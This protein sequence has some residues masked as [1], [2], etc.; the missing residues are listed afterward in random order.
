MARKGDIRIAINEKSLTNQVVKISNL[1]NVGSE[2]YGHYQAECPTFLRRW[3]KT[4]GATLLDEESDD[5]D[6]EG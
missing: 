6:E 5:S 2:G 4:Y 3:K 1:S